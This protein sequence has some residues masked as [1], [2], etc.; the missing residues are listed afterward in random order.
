LAKVLLVGVSDPRLGNVTVGGVE[1]SPDRRV[2][3]AFMIVDDAHADEVL[4]G[5]QSAKGRIRSLL[6]QELGWRYTPELRFGMDTTLDE[7]DNIRKALKH[8][9]PTL[10]IAKDDHGYPLPEAGTCKE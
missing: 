7:A 4:A 3:K 1:V 6:S 10:A 2:A 9:P 8:V 5:L